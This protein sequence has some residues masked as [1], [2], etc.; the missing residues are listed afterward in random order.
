MTEENKSAQ[1]A[2]KARAEAKKQMSEAQKSVIKNRALDTETVKIA[3]GTDHEY[4]LTLQFP[5]TI[6]ASNIMDD[7]RNVFGNLHQTAFMQN[8]IGANGVIKS[9]QIKSL[10]FWDTHA[11]YSECF[12]KVRDFLTERLN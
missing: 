11:G 4:S 6:Q 8:V 2:G 12:R 5:G 3:E 1:V 7:S 9:P 10:Q